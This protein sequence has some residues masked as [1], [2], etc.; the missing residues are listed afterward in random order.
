MGTVRPWFPKLIFL[1]VV[2]DKVSSQTNGDTIEIQI[3]AVYEFSI[4][5]YKMGWRGLEKFRVM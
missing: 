4:I 1:I 3:Q 2:I 5:V